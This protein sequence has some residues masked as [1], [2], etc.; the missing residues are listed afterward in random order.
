MP[1]RTAEC[2]VSIRKFKRPISS[3]NQ[4]SSITHQMTMAREKKSMS[5]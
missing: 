2:E 3:N 5:F 4:D 1:K